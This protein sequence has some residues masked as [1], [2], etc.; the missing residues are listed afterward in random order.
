MGLIDGYVY[1]LIRCA[2]E[3]TMQEKGVRRWTL[4]QLDFEIILNLVRIA[5][6]VLAA[7]SVSQSLEKVMWVVIASLVAFIS[8]FIL[9]LLFM[10]VLMPL[11]MFLNSQKGKKSVASSAIEALFWSMFL[12]GITYLVALAFFGF[13]AL[14]PFEYLNKIPIGLDQS[15]I[16]IFSL[17]AILITLSFFSES[18]FLKKMYAFEPKTIAVETQL[19]DGS[20]NISYEDNPN[21]PDN[22]H[23]TKNSS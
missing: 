11:R 22:Q 5:L 19:P 20:I 14:Q 16:I 21:H 17:A 9:V 2:L 8:Y 12:V 4:A 18:T 13:S 15:S 6:L 7:S 23:I 10:L 3:F 1:M